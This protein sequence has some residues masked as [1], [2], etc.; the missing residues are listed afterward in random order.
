MMALEI[1]GVVLHVGPDV[2]GGSPLPFPHPEEGNHGIVKALHLF[3]EL[4]PQGVPLLPIPSLYGTDILRSGIIEIYRK[5]LPLRLVTDFG[6]NFRLF[7]GAVGLAGLFVFVPKVCEH[8]TVFTGRRNGEQAGQG[9][10]CGY[11]K[12]LHM[13]NPFKMDKNNYRAT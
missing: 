8:V 13:S 9:Q 4:F 2:I 12:I 11:Q 5:V 3:P 6:Q 7:L 1:L 10:Q